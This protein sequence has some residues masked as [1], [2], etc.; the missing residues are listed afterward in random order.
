[1][2]T[3]AGLADERRVLLKIGGACGILGGL[4]VL[5]L[6]LIHGDVAADTQSALRSVGARVDWQFM[7]L[8]FIL[9]TM[10]WVGAFV[11]LADSIADSAGRALARMGTASAVVGAAVGVVDYAIDGYSFKVLAERWVSAPAAERAELERIGDALILILGGT[12]NGYVALLYG[13]PFVLCGL[14]V[15]LGRTYPAWL[16]WVGAAA[17]AG[18]LVAG[19]TGFL[20]ANVVPPVLQFAVF[21]CGTNLWLAVMGIMMWRRASADPESANEAVTRRPTGTPRT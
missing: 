12:F 7:Y 20:S 16:G 19:T 13:L 6:T 3:T 14:A 5:V 2:G 9:G 21:M 8:A 10:L 15:A 17:G 18:C 4:S 1:M 11:A